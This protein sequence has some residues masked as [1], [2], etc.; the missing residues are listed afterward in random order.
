MAEPL[1]RLK[2]RKSTRA[3]FDAMDLSSTPDTDLTVSSFQRG[4][5]ESGSW[6]RRPPHQ[7][8]RTGTRL[9]RRRLTGPEA[10][11]DFPVL[12]DFR[13]QGATSDLV[14]LVWFDRGLE[15][16]VCGSSIT[17]RA[18]GFSDAD[19]HGLQLIQQHFAVALKLTIKDQIART[20]VTTYLAPHA[21]Q[22]VLSHHTQRGDG[23]AIHAAIGR[24]TW[25]TQQPWPGHWNKTCSLSC[26]TATSSARMGSVLGLGGEVL[27]LIG[28]AV[29][30]IFP[31]QGGGDAKRAA[32][33]AALAAADEARQRPGRL[34]E[35]RLAAGL[36]PLD[37]G[38]GL[39]LGEVVFANIGV[40]ERLQATVVGPAAKELA[41]LEA[42]SK[43]LTHPVLASVEFAEGVALDGPWLGQPAR[44][45]VERPR[46]VF[47]PPRLFRANARAGPRH[48]Q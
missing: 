24:A 1:V 11:L 32:C 46:E 25:R 35:L 21:G 26:S 15:P 10:V 36:R 22:Q 19:S 47:A 27:L 2:S 45:G 14:Y 20:V 17:G 29:L 7:L 12:R 42:L 18:A 28:E 44:R 16:G 38:L 4:N 3:A 8:I 31:V 48:L 23:E 13:D 37:F 5:N 9:V 34:N 39:H 33:R 43:D 41:H 40:P 30:A 6:L